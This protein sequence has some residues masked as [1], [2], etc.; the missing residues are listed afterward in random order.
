MRRGV[1]HEPNPL[2]GRADDLAAVL[3]LLRASRVTSI[4]GPGGLGKTRL[5]NAVARD[6][7]QRAV[8]VVALAGVARDGDVEGEVASVL[9]VGEARQAPRRPGGTLPGSWTRSAPARSCSSWT[10]ASTSSTAS[11]YSS[12]PWCR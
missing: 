6:V 2:L 3:D 4:V 8:H 1:A 10:T 11:P 9:G 7:P 5:A 12:A